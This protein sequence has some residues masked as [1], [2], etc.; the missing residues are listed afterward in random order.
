MRAIL[1]EHERCSSNPF[2]PRGTVWTVETRG[3]I[4]D[5]EIAKR[6]GT[7][8]SVIVRLENARHMLTFDMVSRYSAA[9]G[10]KIDIHLVPNG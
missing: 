6:M 10:Q 2:D 1:S 7:S 9:I 5:A 4:V 8:Q 3:P